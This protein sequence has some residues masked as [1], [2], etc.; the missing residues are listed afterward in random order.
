MEKQVNYWVVGATFNNNTLNMLDEFILRGYWY[1]GWSQEDSDN[2]RVKEFLDRSHQIK[3]N[4]RIAIKQLLGQGSSDILIH[5]IGIVKDVDMEETGQIIYVNWLLTNIER[6]VPSHGCF[7]S[8][9]GP[10]RIED[11]WTNKVFCI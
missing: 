3:I 1:L 6:K 7:G 10:F 11:E 5:A 4:D 8:I 2:M 9:Y